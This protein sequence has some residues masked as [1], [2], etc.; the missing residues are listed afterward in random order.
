[1]TEHL[2]ICGVSLLPV[3]IIII[4]AVAMVSAQSWYPHRPSTRSLIAVGASSSRDFAL[5]YPFIIIKTTLYPKE[6]NKIQTPMPYNFLADI[7]LLINAAALISAITSFFFVSTHFFHSNEKNMLTTQ[8]TYWLMIQLDNE[9][10][11]YIYIYISTYITYQ[12]DYSSK[13]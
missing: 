12:L 11:I 3:V 5:A 7:I 9:F 1:M 13:V 6:I 4:V 8:E 10:D 2:S